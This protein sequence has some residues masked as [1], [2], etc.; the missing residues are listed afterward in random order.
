MPPTW[1]REGEGGEGKGT[2]G[3]CAASGPG[4]GQTMEQKQTTGDERR[5]GGAVSH[6][7]APSSDWAKAFAKTVRKSLKSQPGPTSNVAESR[8]EARRRGPETR[9]AAQ[10]RPKG[11]TEPSQ[12]L[13][14]EAKSGQETAKSSQKL[15]KTQPGEAKITL[16]REAGN[17]Q[18]ALPRLPA[19]ETL[20]A[21]GRR[22]SSA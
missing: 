19:G 16:R 6:A 5:S 2:D 17:V 9:T 21:E 8:W 15:A 20:F 12:G 22:Q 11:A 4:A 1:T 7:T 14:G 10:R 18:E 3:K 13:P